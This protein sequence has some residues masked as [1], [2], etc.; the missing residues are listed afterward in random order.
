LIPF[1]TKTRRLID[2]CSSCRVPVQCHVCQT[3]HAHLTLTPD[4][5]RWMALRRGSGKSTLAAAVC[6]RLNA[7][8]GAEIA[9]V[10]PMD[11]FHLS[12]AQLAALPQPDEALRR[13]GAPFTFDADAFVHR[14]RAARTTHD[15]VTKVPAF[16]HEV[17]DPEEDVIS[18]DPSHK[19]VLVEGNYLLLPEEPWCQLAGGDGAALLD[20]TWFVD[21]PVDAAMER[22]MRRHVAVGRTAEEAKTRAD[23]NDR[24]NADLVWANREAADVMVPSY[25]WDAGAGKDSGPSGVEVRVS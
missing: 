12:R 22:V 24:P 6:A 25:D 2:L 17:H 19:V 23:G 20:E 7:A 16:D 10:F 5:S 13:R 21:T 4:E 3:T 8:A 11:G 1:Y 9:V 18:I 15:D 14:V